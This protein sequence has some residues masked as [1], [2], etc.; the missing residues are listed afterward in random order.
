MRDLATLLI[1][2]CPFVKGTSN[3]TW[4]VHWGLS[5]RQFFS[6]HLPGPGGGCR[7][8]RVLVWELSEQRERLRLSDYGVILPVQY[9]SHLLVLNESH[10]ESRRQDLLGQYRNY[11]SGSNIPSV[12]C[13]AVEH[14]VPL[15]ATAPPAGQPWTVHVQENGG[16]SGLY[17]V[18]SRH[19]HC[20]SSV[21][22]PTV[23]AHMVHYIYLAIPGIYYK[24]HYTFLFLGC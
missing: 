3:F 23:R 16:I 18:Q 19:L 1:D 14:E 8:F 11:S 4:A 21:H 22:G 7:Y 17:S 6:Y 10:L 9:L 5:R 20:T 15:W 12:P 2:R 24:I 13:H